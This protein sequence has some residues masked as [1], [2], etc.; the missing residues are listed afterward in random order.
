LHFY[1]FNARLT[2]TLLE[3]PTS[4]FSKKKKQG[5]LIVKLNMLFIFLFFKTKILTKYIKGFKF[6][7]LCNVKI[8]SQKKKKKKKTS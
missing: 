1:L 7:F 8:F 2:F 3:A 4:F 5:L 6:Q